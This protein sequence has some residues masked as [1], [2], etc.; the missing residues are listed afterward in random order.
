MASSAAGKI[1]NV[2]ARGFSLAYQDE[3]IASQ[4]R[5]KARQGRIAEGEADVRRALLRRLKSTGKY[6][7]RTAQVVGTLAGLL[8]EQ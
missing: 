8:V 4:G 1:D 2:P 6:N 5:M 3:L 7:L